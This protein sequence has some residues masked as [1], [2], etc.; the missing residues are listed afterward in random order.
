MI[1]SGFHDYSKSNK[2]HYLPMKKSAGRWQ[3]T[4]LF[5]FMMIGIPYSL[6]WLGLVVLPTYHTKFSPIICIHALLGIY[7]V[8]LILMNFNKVINTDISIKP[9]IPDHAKATGKYLWSC[10]MLQ[11]QYV[12]CYSTEFM[13]MW[14]LR[15]SWSELSAVWHSCMPLPLLGRR[16]VDWRKR[17]KDCISFYIYCSSLP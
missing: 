5:W 11:L 10:Y 1:V 12:T 17:E 15:Q 7:L 3:E 9:I 2:E 13:S 4:F 8:T 6:F 16:K 14:S